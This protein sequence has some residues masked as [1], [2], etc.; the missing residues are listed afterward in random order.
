MIGYIEVHRDVVINAHKLLKDFTCPK[1]TWFFSKVPVAE[2]KIDALKP[3][4]DDL[5]LSTSVASSAYMLIPIDVAN[6][7]IDIYTYYDADIPTRSCC[8]SI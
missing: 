6:A 8:D 3:M 1:K 5:A 4:I 2:Q 7:L